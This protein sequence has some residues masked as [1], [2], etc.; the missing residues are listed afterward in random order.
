M[1]ELEAY[2][3]LQDLVGIFFWYPGTE[4]CLDP[5]EPLEEIDLSA[6][7]IGDDGLCY[8]QFFPKL[9]WLCLEENQISDAGLMHLHVMKQ[10]KEVVLT[11]TNVSAAGIAML[12]EHLLG[13]KITV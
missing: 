8:L 13:C 1:T 6:S 7:G 2:Q 10:L 4:G 11:D 9:S 3:A 5:I 12:K